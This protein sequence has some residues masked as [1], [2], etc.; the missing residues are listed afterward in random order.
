MVREEKKCVRNECRFDMSAQAGCS[1]GTRTV[2]PWG[3]KLLAQLHQVS[4]ADALS[5][6]SSFS[7]RFGVRPP[8]TMTT[9]ARS[10]TRTPRLSKTIR[11]MPS[12]MLRRSRGTSLM[13]VSC[14]PNECARSRWMTF[15]T[16]EI[17][18]SA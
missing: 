7:H 2:S 15:Q 16:A 4:L 10:S 9:I 8:N 17:N 3:A 11:S 14:M 1:F 12:I 13:E 5:G 18:E 6:S